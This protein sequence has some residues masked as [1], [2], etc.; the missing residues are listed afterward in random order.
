MFKRLE[1]CLEK[2]AKRLL[3]QI[4]P[5]LRQE[6]KTYAGLNL[7]GRGSLMGVRT[8]RGFWSNSKAIVDVAQLA[9]PQPG[10]EFII[11]CD[12]CVKGLGGVLAQKNEQGHERPIA[13]ASRLLRDTE[14]RWNITELKAFAV[15]WALE[16][17][18]Q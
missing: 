14:R 2:E 18:Q 6:S 17:F 7:I 16:T 12:A 8:A 4:Y 13:F 11:D 5:T 15:L 10:K 1:V 3:S 9:Y